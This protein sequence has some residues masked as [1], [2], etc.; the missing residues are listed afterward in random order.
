MTNQ[1]I[2]AAAALEE[3]TVAQKSVYVCHCE[4]MATKE[5]QG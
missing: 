4:E 5:D 2:S 1:I 3:A